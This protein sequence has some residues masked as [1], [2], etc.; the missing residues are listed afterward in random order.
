VAAA[1]PNIP[2]RALKLGDTTSL[3]G[4]LRALLAEF[5]LTRSTSTAS[6]LDPVEGCAQAL[7][8]F[9]YCSYFSYF[10]SYFAQNSL[11]PIYSAIL[12]AAIS[13]RADKPFCSQTFS[14][15]IYH[16]P[17]KYGVNRNEMM[18]SK[19]GSA[20]SREIG[21]TALHAPNGRLYHGVHP[22]SSAFGN[23]H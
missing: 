17:K 19:T 8:L 10:D 3:A 4:V 7:L 21:S 18:F 23:L 11:P 1:L 20:I 5:R 22:K 16:P 9:L 2:T 13:H 6:P 15:G 12:I 14:C